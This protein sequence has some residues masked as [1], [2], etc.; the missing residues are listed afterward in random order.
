MDFSSAKKR[1][2]KEKR[3]YMNLGKLKQYL[4]IKEKQKSK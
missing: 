2:D 4:R 3:T 1:D